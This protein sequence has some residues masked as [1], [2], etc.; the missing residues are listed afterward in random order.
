MEALRQ[1]KRSID[2]M[3]LLAKVVKKAVLPGFSSSAVAY[4][5]RDERGEGRRLSVLQIKK[6]AGKDYPRTRE[7]KKK[8][9]TEGEEKKREKWRKNT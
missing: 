2:T 6:K 1:R 3:S 7:Q 8:E 9:S 4:R 5:E